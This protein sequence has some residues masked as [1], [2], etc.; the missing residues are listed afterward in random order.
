MYHN[1]KDNLLFKK[2][3]GIQSTDCQVSVMDTLVNFIPLIFYHISILF[4]NRAILV[5]FLGIYIGFT[6]RL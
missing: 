2:L 4:C 3:Y 1:K 5:N 6:G